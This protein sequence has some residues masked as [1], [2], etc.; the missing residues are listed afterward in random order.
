MIRPSFPQPNKVSRLNP[1][2][3]LCNQLV[4]C[5]LLN[6]NGNKIV[7]DYTMNND[8]IM[9]STPAMVVSEKGYV[10]NFASN[11]IETTTVKNIKSGKVPRTTSVWFF[12]ETRTDGTNSGILTLNSGHGNSGV[13]WTILCCLLSGTFYLWTD[14]VAVNVTCTGSEIPALNVW[15]H[16]VFAYDATN[17]FYYL[18]GVQIKTGSLNSTLA[19]GITNFIVGRRWENAGS[20]M[21]DG[22]IGQVL[23]WNRCLNA[24][25][26]R[27][28]YI[29]PYQMFHLNKMPYQNVPVA[30]NAP[31]NFLQFF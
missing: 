18:N 27:S 12:Q 5:W 21:F 7:K 24:T 22:S 28:L 25:E 8:M 15:N 11:Y 26:V 23:H 14:N 31:G 10:M 19:S 2:H 4:G 17:Y 29:N 30:P 3:P 6:E 16:L 9:G 20:A 1:S 13:S